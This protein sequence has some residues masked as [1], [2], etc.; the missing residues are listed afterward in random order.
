V[1]LQHAHCGNERAT[2][3]AIR[4]HAIKYAQYHDDPTAA[5]QR[6]VA[7]RTLAELDAAIE[8]VFGRRP[9]EVARPL[10]EADAVIPEMSADAG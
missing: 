5:R 6:M 4:T 9:D 7:V 10:T 3:A 8:A 2:L 1:A